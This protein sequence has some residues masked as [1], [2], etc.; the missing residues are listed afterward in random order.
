MTQLPG[1]IHHA[2]RTEFSRYFWAGSLTFL[3]DFTVLVLLTEVAGINYLW[4]N[5]VAVSVGILMSY[6]LC[7]K[8]VF[9][10]RRYNRVVF[11]FPLF[12]LTCGVGILLNELL[13]WGLVE[14]GGRHYLVAKVLVTAVVFVVN[15]SLK[16]II[17]FRR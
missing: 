3:T 2:S 12:V 4:S 8:W 15:F 1:I 16:K 5:L 17:L 10:D 13:L 14:F 11:E 9:L 6:A 7:V